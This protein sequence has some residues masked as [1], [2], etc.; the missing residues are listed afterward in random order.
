VGMA[1]VTLGVPAAV[2]GGPVY[3][4]FRLHKRLKAKRRARSRGFYDANFVPPS[5]EAIERA[6]REAERLRALEREIEREHPNFFN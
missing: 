5:G 3:G 1:V 4:C 6:R 2:I